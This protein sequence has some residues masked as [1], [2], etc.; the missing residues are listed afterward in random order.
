MR[1][2]K[3]EHKRIRDYALLSA[4]IALLIVGVGS[5]LIPLYGCSN[6]VAFTPKMTAR[7]SRASFSPF[8]Q[9]SSVQ[10]G[11]MTTETQVQDELAPV[12]DLNVPQLEQGNDADATESTVEKTKKTLAA[13]IK[14][15]EETRYTIKATYD[16]DAGIPDNATLQVRELKSTTER[17]EELGRLLEVKEDDH[18]LQNVF[19]N[20]AITSD[21]AEVNP[22]T[23][24]ELQ[25]ISS[26]IKP[27][28]SDAVEAAVLGYADAP[29]ITVI[30]RTGIKDNGEEDPK[31]SK[32]SLRLLTDK[33]GDIGLSVVAA[34]KY[35]LD[36]NGV[37]LSVLGGRNTNL[38]CREY[39]FDESL[40]NEKTLVRTL[41]AIPDP[42]HEW[43]TTLWLTKRD[44]R[45]AEEQRGEAMIH[46]V[47]EGEIAQELVGPTAGDGPVAISSSDELAFVWQES[48]QSNEDELEEEPTEPTQDEET[49]SDNDETSQ[50]GEAGTEN[51]TESSDTQQTEQP[52]AED[53]QKS[54]DADSADQGTGVDKQT[55][56]KKTAPIVR[57]HRI[58]A[59]DGRTYRVTA[60]YDSTAGIPRDAQLQV[61]EVVKS[62]VDYVSYVAKGTQA[63][64]VGL[65]DVQLVKVLDISFFDPI[66]GE[67]YQ[68]FKG[69][70][71][72]IELLDAD[73]ADD[74]ELSVAHISDDGTAQ[75]MD[76]TSDGLT[77]DFDTTGF[78]VF[79]IV[80]NT[81]L[82]SE[83]YSYVMGAG[84]ST[85]LS[86]LLTN[87]GIDDQ[88][89]I[90]DITNVTSNPVDESIT[91]EKTQNDW[92]IA[93]TNEFTSGTL[94]LYRGEGD[95]DPIT[96]N[97]S[98][99][100][101]LTITAGSG[102]KEYDGTPLTEDSITSDG[103]EEGDRIESVKV[104]GAQTDVGTAS[105]VPSEAKV[106]NEVGD[107]VTESYAIT[108]VNGTLT[109][110]RR[111]ITITA[112]SE[113]KVYDGYAL[114][115][116]GYTLSSE[117]LAEGDEIESVK[118]TGS[119][120]D[121][122][123]SAS[124]PSGAKIVRSNDEGT[125]EPIDVT[126]NYL[127]NYVSGTLTVTV[128]PI[129][130]TADSAEKPYDGTALTKN[131]YTS[132]GLADGDVF[133]SVTVTGTQTNVGDRA[134][135][136]S[137]A[138]IVHVGDDGVRPANDNYKIEYINGTLKVTKQ[139]LTITAGSDTKAYD[140]TA[141]T[142]ETYTTKNLAE[143]NRIQSISVVGSQT[144]AGTSKNV[145]S[146]AV[147]VDSDGNDV[148]GF[149]EINY[150][151]GALEVIQK[152]VKLTAVSSV[153]AYTGSQQTVEG[154]TVSADGKTLNGVT[155]NGVS[156]SG[157]GTE[158]GSY[159]V[160][161]SGVTVNETSDTT[162]NYV[163]TETEKGTL[164]IT[165]Q[166]PIEKKMSFY[167][168]K[169]SYTINVNPN[170][171]ELNGGNALTLED[172]YTSN[173]TI[174]YSTVTSNNSS[175]SYDYNGQT[176]TFTIPDKTP[177]TITYT[178]RV[179]GAA[180][181]SATFGNTAELGVIQNGS[182]AA[183]Y[184]VTVS[185]TET[186]TPT[187]TDIEGAGDENYIRLYTYAHDYMEVGLGG[188]E[189]RLLDSNQRP[190]T[191]QA[192]EQAGETVTY[193]T[194]ADGYVNVE[195]DDGLVS[196][197]KNTNYYLEMVT[198]P[199]VHEGNN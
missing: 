81:T 27:G 105:N 160:T 8:L 197:R 151:D 72:S 191:Y 107:D 167:G 35:E 180:G 155:F 113:T 121:V 94:M 109:V 75:P 195:L 148:T 64:G 110:N 66:S 131:S 5:A 50:P 18:V 158:E 88:V 68:P 116:T 20:V 194:G 80:F 193:E 82:N 58:E 185:R 51:Q 56:E 86:T 53:K 48:V 126:N 32:T 10:K 163:V 169:A 161:L 85:E 168:N 63:L 3:N 130:I 190:I 44:N 170:G 165:A 198:A 65:P 122:G 83:S 104:T 192:G 143:G 70:Q 87:L 124:I 137:E 196:I 55:T 123:E 17:V 178:T 84:E 182:F 103:L 162:G 106:V 96:I 172:T 43:P 173:Q 184:A 99:K 31:P 159:D 91:A 69:V 22:A 179:S 61:R 102:D 120:T 134:N 119:Q 28:E 199:V 189:F 127:I 1:N 176:G 118:V 152:R 46:L 157:S 133:D 57:E 16:S 144:N 135:I 14:K 25:I 187:D 141:L 36:L 92:T 4:V 129:T 175:V 30:N 146:E 177:V 138:K 98:V 136:P 101:S 26:I 154:F 156:A 174:D 93:T 97:I 52:Q 74:G 33:L 139:T 183:W 112:D 117:G 54:G 95:S 15:D 90:A 19:I 149:Y 38:D 9:A 40:G 89:Q 114:T 132:T 171:L 79:V 77:V 59:S 108:Y 47:R 6:I 37:T 111:E 49:T 42:A 67:T 7:H 140:G 34:S 142:N 78:S 188:A 62:D 100:P 41:V 73:V 13:T 147:I 115:N 128:K 21:G 186:I 125:D 45:A 153:K 150:E 11:T 12:G 23:P 29:T 2:K 60:S 181:T 164:L 76:T 24:I 39:E 71:V 145:A 166:P